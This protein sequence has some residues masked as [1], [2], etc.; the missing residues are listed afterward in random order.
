[1][2]YPELAR[3]A[4]IEG[5]VIVQTKIDIDGNA[6]QSKII[7][8]IEDGGINEAAINAIENTK[9]NP[10]LSDNQPVAVWITIPVQFKLAT[11]KPAAP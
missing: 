11:D 2:I 6:S 10:A 4:G 8:G 7:K 5:M 1:M 9:W 3:E